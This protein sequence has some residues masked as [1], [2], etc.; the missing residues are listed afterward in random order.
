MA[1]EAMRMAVPGVVM[2]L[3]I[4]G[5]V[6]IVVV[7]HPLLMRQECRVTQLRATIR[8]RD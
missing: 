1:A 5:T 8:R 2:S 7:R 4:V 3:M 6:V